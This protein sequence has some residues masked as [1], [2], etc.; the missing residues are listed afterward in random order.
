MRYKHSTGVGKY[1]V[2]SPADR[3]A[4]IVY[5]RLTRQPLFLISGSPKPIPRIA[6]DSFFANQV[7]CIYRHGTA[8][9]GRTLLW[10]IENRMGYKH[11]SGVGK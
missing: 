4:I 2:A 3:P 8:F 5:V 7:D 1:V 11:G 10:C 9:E 6:E